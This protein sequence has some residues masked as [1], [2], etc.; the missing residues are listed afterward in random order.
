MPLCQE[1]VEHRVLLLWTME[2][3]RRHSSVHPPTA[4]GT[5]EKIRKVSYAGQSSTSRKKTYEYNPVPLSI[6]NLKEEDVYEEEDPQKIRREKG[7]PFEE[8][9]A[10]K[11]SKLWNAVQ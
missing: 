10:L 8:D 1:E 6:V 3:H 9:F 2:K 5:G 7:I 11:N 4:N